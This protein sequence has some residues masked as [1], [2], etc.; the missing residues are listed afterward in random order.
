MGLA[1]A[2]AVRGKQHQSVVEVKPPRTQAQRTLFAFCHCFH[3]H[4]RTATSACLYVRVVL[5]ER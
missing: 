5:V 2:L 4:C 1:L 3:R